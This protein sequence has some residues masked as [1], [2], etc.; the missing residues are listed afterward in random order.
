MVWGSGVELNIFEYGD[1]KSFL[2]DYISAQ[3]TRGA[4]AELA[5]GAG[6]DRT[7]LSQALNG[8][9][10]LTTD[11]VINFGETMGMSETEKNFF[12]HLLLHDRAGQPSA[13]SV[14]KRK[15]EKI[16]QDSQ[17][18]AKRIERVLTTDPGM[19]VVRHVDAG[20]EEAKAFAKKTDVKVPMPK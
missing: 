3:E 16:S 18:M 5:K 12:L 11:H 1:Y 14:L 7:Y 8:K 10:H 19:G 13:R 4:V 6:C 15:L 2:R 9:V 17:M 20:Y